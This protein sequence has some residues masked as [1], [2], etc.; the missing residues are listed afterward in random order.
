[1]TRSGVTFVNTFT[2]K[3]TRKSSNGPQAATNWGAKKKHPKRHTIRQQAAETHVHT[4]TS[5]YIPLNSSL[6]QSSSLLRL[7]L[8]HMLGVLDRIS[9]WSA[10]NC[11]LDLL[12]CEKKKKN[13]SQNNLISSAVFWGFFY[14]FLFYIIMIPSTESCNRPLC[15]YGLSVKGPL[16]V[17]KKL[18]SHTLRGHKCKEILRHFCEYHTCVWIYILLHN[19]WKKKH[20]VL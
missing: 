14:S 9:V 17:K 5:C 2:R 8:C 15:P 11:E 7:F 19:C 6:T 16:A 13:T 3:D 20:R 18:A 1:M 10:P 12:I 4:T